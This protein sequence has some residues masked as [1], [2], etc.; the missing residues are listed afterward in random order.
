MS[1]NLQII[2]LEQHIYE[3]TDVGQGLTKEELTYHNIIYLIH[4][5]SAVPFVWG[6]LSLAPIIISQLIGALIGAI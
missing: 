2:E 5:C 1:V 4:S 3:M 6:S